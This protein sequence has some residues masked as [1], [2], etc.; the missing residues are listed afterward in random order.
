MTDKE[1]RPMK[2]EKFVHEGQLK[3][4]P[5]LESPKLDGLRCVI[6]D[7][8]ALSANLEPFRN[9][10]VQ[11][12]LGRKEYNG[13][14]GELI[15]GAPTG[16]N[17]LGRSMG[18]MAIATRPD[19]TFWVFDDFSAHAHDF[20]YRCGRAEDRV[21]DIGH[22]RVKHLEH[23]LVETPLEFRRVEALNLDRGFEGTML[24]NMRAPYKFGYATA[25]E[26]WLWKVKRFIDGE[27]EIVGYEEGKVNE[28]PAE[29]DGRGLTKRGTK[30]EFMT[31]SGLLGTL[32]GRDLKTGRPLRISPGQ[33]TVQERK[34]A[35][36]NRP[37]LLKRI[38]TYRAFDY[39]VKDELR[40]VTFHSWR[41]LEDMTRP[42]KGL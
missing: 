2:A 32:L 1:F 16:G 40:F 12:V 17:V 30:K 5:Y 36:A 3:A 19:F 28:N 23:S 29:L 13:L 34:D 38:A 37:N 26:D 7:G 24:R 6:R 21:H 10:F 11:E 22:P 14:D 41:P 33:M 25:A 27:A 4:W 39:G 35:W 18:V 8:R 20:N 42:A 31:P 15:V 9:H